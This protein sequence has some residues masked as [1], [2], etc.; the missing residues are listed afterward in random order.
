MRARTVFAVLAAVFAGAFAHADETKPLTIGDKTP[1]LPLDGVIKGKNLEAFEPGKTY[2]IEFWATWCGP[3]ISAMPHL[4]DMADKFKG[5]AE[6]YSVNTWDYTKTPAPKNAPVGTPPSVES[7]ETH[8][9]RVK[10]WVAKNDEKM[11]YNVVFDDA[12]DTISTTWMRAAGR[13]GIPC[14]FIVN[15]EG[16]IAWIGHPMSMDKPLAD[17]VDGKWDIAKFKEQF[18][19]EAAAQKAAAEAQKK[20]TADIKANN[21]EAVDAY[22]AGSKNK[23]SAVITLI[24]MAAASNPDMAVKYYKANYGKLEGTT[25]V[26]WCFLASAILPRVSNQDTKN[27]IVKMSEDCTKSPDPKSAAVIYA[28]HARAVFAAGNKESALEWIKKA[29]AAIETYPE[30]GRESLVNFL[31]ST[32]ASFN[33]Q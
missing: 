21:T 14:A 6:F 30:A 22:I 7:V 12:K 31:N 3:C 23:T 33:K 26:D 32:E 25:A 2:V 17:I 9:A 4:S 8:K 18:D 27:E 29:R 5:K 11:R 16:Q 15:G 24:Q 20:L 28:Y 1:P 10:E 19:K 13:N